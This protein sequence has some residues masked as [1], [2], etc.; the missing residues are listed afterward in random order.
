MDIDTPL[1]SHSNGT[2]TGGE[3]N[4]FFRAVTASDCFVDHSLFLEMQSKMGL[5]I[6]L[7]SGINAL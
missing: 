3:I 1:S 2:N 4:N 6:L 5:A 7:Q